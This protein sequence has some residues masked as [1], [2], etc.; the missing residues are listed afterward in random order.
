M[1]VY[2][3]WEVVG[4]VDALAVGQEGQSAGGA[5]GFDPPC[6]SS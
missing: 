5:D 4:G 6:F 2:V 1:A 3:W